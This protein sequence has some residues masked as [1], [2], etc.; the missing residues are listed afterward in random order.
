MSYVKHK[1]SSNKASVMNTT[2]AYRYVNMF[3]FI[4]EYTRIYVYIY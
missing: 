1:K 3:V 2:N 4:Y